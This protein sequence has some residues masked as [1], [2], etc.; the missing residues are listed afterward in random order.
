M[1]SLTNNYQMFVFYF[2][3]YFLYNVCQ[4]QNARVLVIVCMKLDRLVSG[5]EI[6]RRALNIII[7][8]KIS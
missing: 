2:K 8:V 3:L 7:E 1:K 4:I 6:G 5:N